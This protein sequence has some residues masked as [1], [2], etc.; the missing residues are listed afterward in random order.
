[1]SSTAGTQVI[2]RV[3]RAGLEL[4]WAGRDKKIVSGKGNKPGTIPR[5][6]ETLW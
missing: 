5:S 6:R 3:R 1:M 4:E 2:L